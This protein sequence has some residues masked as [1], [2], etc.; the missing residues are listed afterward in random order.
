MTSLSG[1]VEAPSARE[2]ILKLLVAKAP[3]EL[4]AADVIRACALFGISANNARVA[5][6][7]LLSQAL[8]EWVGRGSYRLGAQGIALGRAVSA[9]RTITDRLRPWEG[10]WIA[11]IPSAIAPRDRKA[12]RATARA[13]SLF[14]FRELDGTL[15]VR[16]DNLSDGVAAMRARLVDLGL[17]QAMH[18]FQARD[19]D[20]GREAQARALWDTAALEHDY[21]ETGER[22]AA[23]LHSLPSLPVTDAARHAWLEGDRAIRQLLFDPLLPE[24]L[25][26]AERR[27]QFVRCVTDYDRAGQAAWQR[28]WQSADAADA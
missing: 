22:L 1:A 11:A 13:L 23:S 24:P 16:P 14:G 25:V 6:N 15:H 28:F 27:A 8:I 12:A 2:L 20:A 21:T 4:A 3:H 10:A 5:L 18:V 7:R 17:S 26:A 9:W 19:F